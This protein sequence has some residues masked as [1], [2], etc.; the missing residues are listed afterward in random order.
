MKIK[1]V[2]KWGA[3]YSCLGCDFKWTGYCGPWD[4]AAPTRKGFCP[5]C[6]HLYAKWTNYEELIVRKKK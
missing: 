4:P 2:G 3:T 1:N 5:M 6:G